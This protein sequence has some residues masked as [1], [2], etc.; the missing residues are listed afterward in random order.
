METTKSG[1]LVPEGTIDKR[2]DHFEP[3]ETEAFKKGASVLV[4][5]ELAFV[6]ICKNCADEN[7][8]YQMN[9]YPDEHGRLVAE[10][11]CRRITFRERRKSR[12]VGV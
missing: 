3:Y 7:R 12:K 8:H 4:R 2:I 10:C 1:L 5:H 9:V 11:D 6:V